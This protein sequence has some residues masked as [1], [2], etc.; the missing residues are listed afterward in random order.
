MGRLNEYFDKIYCINLDRRPDR[1]KH[2]AD[3]FAREGL[4][5]QRFTAIDKN[6]I[7]G[8]GAITSG[9]L[10]C[11]SS[12]RAI[13]IDAINNK[14]DKIL[15]LEDD[16]VFENGL[17]KF[18]ADN[19]DNVPNDWKFLYLGGNHL[20][21]LSKINDNIYRMVSSLA[22]HAYGLRTEIIP[23]ILEFIREP[24][25]P[26]DIY[27]AQLHRLLPSYVIKNGDKSITWQKEDYSDIDESECDYT[28]LK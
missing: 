22:T 20:N 25:Y 8:N 6:D 4:N 18:F 19:V 14:Y 1:W 2:C 12:H 23:T 16:V 11:M 5:V 28:W 26:I 3:L 10:A 27:Y 15:I 13:M 7:S 24:Q 17:D 21:G 9:Q